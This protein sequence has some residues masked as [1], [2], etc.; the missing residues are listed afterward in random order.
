M[1]I[2]HP[3]L[4]QNNMIGET[5]MIYAICKTYHTQIMTIM[6][7]SISCFTHCHRLA[8]SIAHGRMT[9]ARHY[10]KR[11]GMATSAGYSWTIATLPC[12]NRCVLSYDCFDA[13][14]CLTFHEEFDNVDKLIIY[15]T[16]EGDIMTYRYH[17]QCHSLT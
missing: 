9:L 12:V 6:T 15:L 13:E 10:S 7:H 8:G 11:N 16:G 17:D 5:K 4:W 14:G 2:V 1:T 3:C